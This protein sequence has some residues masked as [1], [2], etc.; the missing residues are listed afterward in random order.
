M[1]FLMKFLNKITNV[2][3]YIILDKKLYILQNKKLYLTGKN[4]IIEE[5]YDFPSNNLYEYEDKIFSGKNFFFDTQKKKIIKIEELNNY[6]YTND[7]YKDLLIFSNEDMILF[8]VKEQKNLI[9][10][11]FNEDFGIYKLLDNKFIGRGD[12]FYNLCTFDNQIL[13]QH[14]FSDLLQGEAIEQVGNIIVCNN[15][16]YLCLKD[17]KNEKNNATFCIEVETGKVTDVYRGFYGFLFLEEGR[18]YTSYI[19]FLKGLNLN[20]GEI[21]EY[22]FEEILKP[23]NLKIHW[24]KSVVKDNKLYFVDFK[25][26]STNRMGI[27][28]LETKQL[29]WQKDFEINDGINNNIQEIR[30]IDNRLYVHCSDNTLHI[31][32]RE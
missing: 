20:S 19:Y 17:G 7:Y 4:E 14:T 13:W 22:N 28:D 26:Y 6:Y 18:I 31:F 5:H 16:L 12:D 25:I 24:N 27:I 30:V 32:E 11:P 15:H 23:L 8:S 3:K 2:D 29:I 1:K 9:H 21:I 10:I